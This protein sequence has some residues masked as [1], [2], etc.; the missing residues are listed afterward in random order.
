[1]LAVVTLAE[2]SL[3]KN[4]Q[5]TKWEQALLE[6]QQKLKAEKSA[7]LLAQ[8][9]GLEKKEKPPL[10]CEELKDAEQGLGAALDSTVMAC[11]DAKIAKEEAP[12]F[13]LGYVPKVRRRRDEV[14]DLKE[15]L[16]QQSVFSSV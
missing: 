13:E 2:Q 15:R 4:R 3:D 12:R 6:V 14:G 11:D 1:M 16:L 7:A 8:H 9:S 10:C 5:V